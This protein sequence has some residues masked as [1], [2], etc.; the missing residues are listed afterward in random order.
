VTPRTKENVMTDESTHD[1]PEVTGRSALAR[2]VLLLLAISGVG[3]IMSLIGEIAN[4]K[5]FDNG[6][7][8]TVAGST[9]WFMYFFGG[10]A[11]LIAGVIAL[12][13]GMRGGPHS[14]RQAGTRAIAYAVASVA[15]I[16]VFDAFVD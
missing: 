13:R 11:A 6:G 15:F 2:A 16:V 1:A 14:E 4:W 7:E 5:G 10:I 9:F 8:S 3:L 12:V